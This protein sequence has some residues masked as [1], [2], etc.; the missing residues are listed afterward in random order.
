MSDSQWGNIVVIIAILLIVVIV[1][2]ITTINRIAIK[3]EPR[4]P[5]KP[6]S[7]GLVRKIF[8]IHSGGTT[9]LTLPV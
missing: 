4:E 2:I 5:A 7:R 6:P 1:A 9:C 3:R 8:R